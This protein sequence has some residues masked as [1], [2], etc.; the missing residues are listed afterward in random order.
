MRILA[1]SITSLLLTHP[2]FVERERVEFCCLRKLTECTFGV[3]VLWFR[4]DCKETV[5]MSLPVADHSSSDGSLRERDTLTVSSCMYCAFTC[6]SNWLYFVFYR[7]L[8]HTV[9]C[10]CPCH[11]PCHCQCPCHCSASCHCDCPCHCSAGCHVSDQS[12]G[13]TTA[14]GGPR[15][16]IIWK[17]RNRSVQL[18]NVYTGFSASATVE[19]RCRG[20]SGFGSV[21][22]WVSEWVLS[23]CDPKPCE[24]H[25]SQTNKG[26]FTKF[27]SQ[28]YLCL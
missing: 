18:L 15:K 8:R 22:L 25:F 20:H 10:H 11:C 24:Q 1:G 27:W 21:C 13:E 19:Q 9:L 5:N 3:V 2:V 23:L 7:T 28:M 26:N 6:S 14:D 4:G 17:D 12:E 16:I